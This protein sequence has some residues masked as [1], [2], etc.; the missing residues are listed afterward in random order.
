M[1]VEKDSNQQRF[2]NPPNKDHLLPT[3]FNF[4]LQYFSNDNKCK[5]WNN[6]CIS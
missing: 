1:L 4:V 6:F 3:H 5:G 2:I